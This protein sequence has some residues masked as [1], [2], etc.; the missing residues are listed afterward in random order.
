MGFS[1]G[2]CVDSLAAHAP[3]FGH[4]SPRHQ[5]FE[6]FLH[7]P[8]C[9][10]GTLTRQ[11][12]AEDALHTIRSIRMCGEIIAYLFRNRDYLFA[13]YVCAGHATAMPVFIEA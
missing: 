10:C 2:T 9:L 8:R 11:P 1:V 7:V 6:R 5:I 12:P 13:C 3:D 4:D